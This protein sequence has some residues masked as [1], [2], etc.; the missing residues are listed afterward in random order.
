MNLRELNYILF[1]AWERFEH[2]RLLR[3]LG[4]IP[5]LTASLT[6]EGQVVFVAMLISGAAGI[7]VRFSH[8]YLVFCGLVGLL[9]AAYLCRPMARLE[10]VSLRVEHPGRVAAGEVMTFTIVVRN[11]GPR[12]VYALRIRGPFLPWDVSWVGGVPSIACLEPGREA[13]VTLRARFLRRGHRALGRFRAMSVRPLGLVS[14]RRILGEP[15]EVTVV[16]RVPRIVGLRRPQDSRRAGERT[17]RGAV[18]GE[19]FELLGVR[20]YRAGDRIRDL[21]A[22]SWARVGAPIVREYRRPA[23]ER[24]VVMLSAVAPGVPREIFDAAVEL[25]AGLAAAL[26]RAEADVALF[27]VGE[28]EVAASHVM[29]GG[30]LEPMLDRL[31]LAE[32]VPVGAFDALGAE[33]AR[34]AAAHLV[35]ARWD[36]AAADVVERVRRSGVPIEAWVVARHGVAGG[37]R[38]LRPE[39][40][41]TGELRV[42]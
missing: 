31:A 32:V 1:P 10:G 19:S 26:V 15:V 38:A 5:E 9:V 21:H 16:P 23:Q 18:A 14:G 12:P 40:I 29:R 24:V 33:V 8:L 3:L 13:R 27:V 35:F 22:R 25:T 41:A 36:A 11:E 4:P 6:H 42:A 37:A 20:P 7:D 2:S 28:P 34:A 17:A 30:A 39:E